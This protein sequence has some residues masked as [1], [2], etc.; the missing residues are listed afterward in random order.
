MSQKFTCYVVG[1]GSLTLKC[2][3]VLFDRGHEIC[4]IISSNPAIINWA[5]NNNIENLQLNDTLVK[6]L[7]SKSYD[8]LFSIINF[9]ILPAEI[10]RSPQRGAIN[11]H[12]GPLPKYAGINATSWAIMNQEKTYGITWHKITTE[13]DKGDIAKQVFF[14]I[15]KDETTLSLNARCFEKGLSSFV[16]LVD[17]LANGTAKKI[18]QKFF[19][20]T[21]F[22]KTKRPDRAAIIN[23]DAGAEEISALA[24]ALDFGRYANSLGLPKVKVGNEYFIVPE[25]AI[26]SISSTDSPG[27]ITAIDKE[28][29]RV[30]TRTSDIEFRR[31]LTIDGVPLSIKRLAERYALRIGFKFFELDDHSAKDI[32]ILDSSIA[33]RESYWVNLLSALENIDIRYARDG[34]ALEGISNF[35]SERVD[36]PEEILSYFRQLARTHKYI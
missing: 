12:D 34:M 32:T 5:A 18:E 24:R 35:E 14:D 10:I 8:Y 4:G 33:K 36:I 9:S 25:I 7:N 17:E 2:S 15:A 19:D 11:F 28:S 22:P 27:V 21:Y 16:E 20:R 31:A 3:E 23:W 13:V 26:T 6:R 30:A 29:V 1:D